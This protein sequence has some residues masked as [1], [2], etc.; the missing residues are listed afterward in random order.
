[1]LHAKTEDKLR[2]DGSLGSYADLSFTTNINSGRTRRGA[3]LFWVKRE[4]ITDR[5]V[6]KPIG[7]TKQTA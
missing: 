5:K 4:E 6:E 2:A 3:P 1:M 7:Q